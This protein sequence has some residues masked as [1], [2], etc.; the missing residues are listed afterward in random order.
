MVDAALNSEVQAILRSDHG[1]I[2]SGTCGTRSA[3]GGSRVAC[4]AGGAASRRLNPVRVGVEGE[5]ATTSAKLRGVICASHAAFAR[6]SNARCRID[7]VST[8]ALSRVLRTEVLVIRAKV[9]AVFEGD[10]V[11]AHNGTRKS[12]WVGRISVAV[13][14]VEL[15]HSFRVACRGQDV[16]CTIREDRKSAGATA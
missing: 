2:G 8:K 6:S 3:T 16:G 12:S 15:A 1:A 13:G 14:V 4:S 10:G 11:T 5:P 7:A 9:G